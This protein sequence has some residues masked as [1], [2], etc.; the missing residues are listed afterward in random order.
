MLFA[1]IKQTGNFVSITDVHGSDIEEGIDLLT[2]SFPCQDLSLCGA[3]HGNN[4]WYF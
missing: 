4:E 1:A 3:W 2:Y